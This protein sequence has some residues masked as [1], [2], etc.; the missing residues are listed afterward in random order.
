MTNKYLTEN[1]HYGFRKL[2]QSKDLTLKD[3]RDATKI[4]VLRLSVIER[5]QHPATDEECHL[6][7]GALDTPYKRIKWLLNVHPDCWY[8]ED[9]GVIYPAHT[10]PYPCPFCEK[11]KVNEQN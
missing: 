8:C 2:R 10:D 4:P 11:G 5:G 6:L 1:T 3:L 7:A 9:R